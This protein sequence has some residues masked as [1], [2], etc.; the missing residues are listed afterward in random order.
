MVGESEREWG[1]DLKW[2]VLLFFTFNIKN[3]PSIHFK[4][5]PEHYQPKID[6]IFLLV[7]K[8][9]VNLWLMVFAHS[10]ASYKRLPHSLVH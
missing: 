10:G 1:N 8:L 2:I 9:S 3:K 7:K 5:V 6:Y 4:L